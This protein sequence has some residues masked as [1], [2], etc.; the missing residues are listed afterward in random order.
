MRAET[1]RN[2]QHWV[3]SAMVAYSPLS[4]KVFGNS[5]IAPTHRLSFSRSLVMSRLLFNVHVTVLSARDY[6][7]YNDVYMRVLRRIADNPRFGAD[8]ERTETCEHEHSSM[9]LP[10][11]A[12]SLRSDWHTLV[13][14]CGFVHGPYLV[15]CP[16]AM[17]ASACHVF[18]RWARIA[19]D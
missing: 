17:R 7:A 14:L 16:F 2:T 9:L 1:F 18:T 6:I 5:L 12:W 11:I 19:S 13:E 10:L 4:F 3:Q 15:P 8:T